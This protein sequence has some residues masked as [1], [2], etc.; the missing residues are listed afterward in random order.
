MSAVLEELIRTI[1]ERHAFRT[2]DYSLTW[3]GDQFDPSRST[4][5]LLITVADGRH[6]STQIIYRVLSKRDP[7]KYVQD[8]SAAFEGLNRR[9]RIRAA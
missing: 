4:H 8:I 5:D 3:D 7:W 9:A 2:R 6:V 1:A